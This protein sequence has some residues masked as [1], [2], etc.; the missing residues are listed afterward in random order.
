MHH[1]TH[2][3]GLSDPIVIK[4]ATDHLLAES[5]IIC[6]K[7]MPEYNLEGRSPWDVIQAAQSF[8][9]SERNNRG[10]YQPKR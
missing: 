7:F 2:A 9:F 3:I 6:K 5:I 10:N 1:K 4:T 8:K